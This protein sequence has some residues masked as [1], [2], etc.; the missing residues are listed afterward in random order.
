MSKK[1]ITQDYTRIETTKGITFEELT[2]KYNQKLEEL[3]KKY[4]NVHDVKVTGSSHE[5]NDGED[6]VEELEI[7]FRRNETDVEYKRRIEWQEYRK[8]ENESG[9][10]SKLKELVKKY[11]DLAKELCSAES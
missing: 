5:Y 6:W 3:H 11:P 10:K 8:K 1:R 9:E 2:Q 4:D 7:R